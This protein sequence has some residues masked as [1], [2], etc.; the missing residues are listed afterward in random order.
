MYKLMHPKCGGVSFY[1]LIKPQI[2]R[3]I[4]PR[5]VIYPDGHRPEHFEL[6]MCGTCGEY[7]ECIE[8]NLQPVTEQS[9]ITMVQELLEILDLDELG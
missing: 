8:A 2:G 7:A 1:I 4:E 3:P 9:E 5:H 6:A